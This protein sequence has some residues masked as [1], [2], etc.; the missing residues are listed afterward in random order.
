MKKEQRQ[1]AW[2]NKPQAP[3]FTSTEKTSLLETIKEATAKL[4]KISEK[5]SRIEM[6]SNRIYMYELVEQFKPEGAVYI[7]PLI[8]G[9]YVE[10]PYARITLHDNRGDVCTADFQR[11]TG[12]WMTLYTGTMAEC[13]D[14]IENDDTWF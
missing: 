9:K 12:Q 3:K 2:V 14:D 6:R 4:P 1:K 11:H 13:I 5:V 10:F 7:K 8:D